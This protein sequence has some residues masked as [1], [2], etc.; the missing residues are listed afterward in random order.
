MSEFSYDVGHDFNRELLPYFFSKE[1]LVFFAIVFVSYW[2]IR[3]AYRRHLLTF[4]SYVFYGSRNWRFLGLLWLSTLTDYW[5]ARWME[6]RPAK[7]RAFLVA[8]II[9][10]LGQ[11]MI[12]KYLNFFIASAQGLSSALG[13]PFQAGTLDIVLPLGISFYTFQS[14]AYTIDVYRGKTSAVRDF[15]TFTAFGGFFPQL[16][17]GPIEKASTLVPQLRQ[18]KS[19]RDVDYKTA[20]YLFAYGYFKKRVIADFLVAAVDRAFE[21][22]G[23]RG[24][25]IW[26]G[27]LSCMIRFYCDVSGYADMA[28]GIALFLGIRLSKNFDFPYFS[29]NPV[30]FWNRWHIT[31]SHWVR[32]YL[33]NPLLL[34]LRRPVLALFISFAVMGAWHGA[35]WHFIQWGLY[36]AAVSV[37]YQLVLKRLVLPRVPWVGVTPLALATMC[38]V[39]LVGQSFFRAESIEQ[40][41]RLWSS[42]LDFSTAAGFATSGSAKALFCIA[43]VGAYEAFLFRRRD[44]LYVTVQNFYVQATFYGVLYFLYRNIGQSAAVDFVYFRF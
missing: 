30:E 29:R 28:R 32:F 5:C 16:I 17:A 24:I 19:W 35:S 2:T 18:A 38:A 31:L 36:W 33:Y 8:S 21:D 15:F 42:A 41:C 34:S 10:N 25:S 13:I 27:F 9:V 39:T 20:F 12:F 22:P 26:V 37:F 7:K 1:F 6:D 3:P 11:L 4:A 43:I 40:Y 14:L 23:A 44:E